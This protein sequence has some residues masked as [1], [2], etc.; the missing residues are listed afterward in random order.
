MYLTR[1]AVAVSMAVLAV[2]ACSQGARDAGA[3][4]GPPV[5]SPP[6]A[7]AFVPSGPPMALGLSK[8]VG[9]VSSPTQDV[10][11]A[12]YFNQVTPEN[13][14]KWGVAEATRDVM[15]WTGLDAAYALAKDNRLKAPGDPRDGT[16]YPLPFRLHTLVYGK[17]Q[18]GWVESLPPDRQRVE[19]ERWFAAVAARYPA[20]DFIDVVNEPLHNPPVGSGHGNYIA[21]LGGSGASGWDWVIAAFEMGRRFFPAA[22]LGVNEYNVT[23]DAG[24]ARDYRALVDL[25]RARRLVDYVGVQGH[26][27]ETTVSSATTLANL[28][29]LAGAGLPVYITEFDI[30]GATDEAQLADYQRIFPL[31]WEHPAVRGITLW[32]YR[33]GL[34]RQA[35]GAYI[36]LDNGA[37]RPAMVWL[38]GYVRARP[39]S[40]LA[41]P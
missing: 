8:F 25:L 6:G 40:T 3:R 21:A 26:A 4:G 36:V 19:I 1:M 2:F 28:D 20:I 17:Q 15:D 10:N 39:A 38:Q 31:F 13:G 29:L 37:E 9:S 7:S 24:L 27:F 11:M 35:Q 18:P 14:G 12:A 33:P 30:D 32:G 41:L 22:R 23:N 16:P 5:P 34:W